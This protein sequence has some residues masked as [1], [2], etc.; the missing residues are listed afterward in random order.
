MFVKCSESNLNKSALYHT[1]SESAI[2]HIWI[3][4]K[5]WV[6]HLNELQALPNTQWTCLRHSSCLLFLHVCGSMILRAKEWKR[7]RVV[8]MALSS[9]RCLRWF[10]KAPDIFMSLAGKMLHFTVYVLGI[11]C[12]GNG[13]RAL[14][15]PMKAGLPRE[16]SGKRGKLLWRLFDDDVVFHM[17]PSFSM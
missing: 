7:D 13:F 14:M 6:I 8:V 2:Q 12:H 17:N 5:K 1:I 4:N 9:G 15:K 16:I 10:P 3:N 11:S